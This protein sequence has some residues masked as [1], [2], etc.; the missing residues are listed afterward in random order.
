M[1][2][3]TTLAF[4]VA[5]RFLFLCGSV[6]TASPLPITGQ[7]VDN[8]QQPVAYANIGVMNTPFGTV[9]DGQGRFTLYI[10]DKVT[11]VDTVSISLIGYRTL[12]VTVAELSARLTVNPLL[13]I[14]EEPQ[15]LKE[16]RITAVNSR[17]VTQ[18]KT[19]FQTSMCTNFALSELPRQNLGAE[20]GR[21]F[22]VSKGV[23]RL[24]TYRFYIISNYDSTR[25]RINVYRAKD[26][27]N[28]LPKN[29]YVTVAGKSRQ[30]VEVD[31]MPYQLVTS[32]D[33]IVAV[34]WVDSYGNGTALQMPIQMPAIATHYYRYGSQD[35]WKRFRGMTTSMNLTFTRSKRATYS[36]DQTPQAPDPIFPLSREIVERP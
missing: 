22:N 6:A 11:Q 1:N 28:L 14:E 12:H 20:I 26:M 9:A 5:I 8:H 18:G 17:V 35:R 3:K 19:G 21:R 31:L 23:N 16:V 27:H 13:M 10:T 15:Q 34:Q 4:L 30:W 32:D 36:Q 29:I 33:V 2:M 25:F 7:L 24:E